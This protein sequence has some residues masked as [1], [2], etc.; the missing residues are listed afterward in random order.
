MIES[1]I[2]EINYRVKGTEKF[3]NRPD[4]AEHIL[5]VRAAS[6][7][8][9]RPTQPMD[10]QS[11]GIAVSSKVNQSEPPASTG[12]LKINWLYAPARECFCWPIAAI[13]I[14]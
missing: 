9:R 5:Q 2:K 14:S 10:P 7:M 13:V 12:Q 6:L 4:G 1:L 3:W 8:R 11:P